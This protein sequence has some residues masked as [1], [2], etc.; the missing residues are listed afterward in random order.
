M[1]I[2]AMFATVVVSAVIAAPADAKTI[3]GGGFVSGGVTC[4][5]G[6]KNVYCTYQGLQEIGDLDP[7]LELRPNGKAVVSEA[8]GL[9]WNKIPTAKIKAGDSWSSK[10]FRCNVAK[11]KVSCFIKG[12]GMVF[13]PNSSKAPVTY[14][15]PRTKLPETPLF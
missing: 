7:I 15:T 12:K 2:I 4:G 6:G 11:T 9:M 1:K 5:I 13:Y 10:G 3:H 8:G 14:Q